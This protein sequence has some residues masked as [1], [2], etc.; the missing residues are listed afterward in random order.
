[1][2]FKDDIILENEKVLLRPLMENDIEHLKHF[3][4]QEPEI[5]TYSLMQI[6][7]VDDLQKYIS[8]AITA[9]EQET[10][11]PFI[12]Y[13]K[14]KKSYAG[15]TRFYDIQLAYKTL[16][17]GYT[18]YGSEFQGT[19]VNKNCKYLLLQHAF[20]NLDMVRVEFRADNKNE[21]SKAAMKSIGCVEE[22]V[23]RSNVPNA[24]GGR[25]DSIVLSI[26]QDEWHHQ[27]KEQLLQKINVTS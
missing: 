21:R 8:L 26:L 18:W 11:Y 19:A 12:V 22:G 25:R 27:V 15:S 3:V 13:D 10:A 24:E 6:E 5:W 7:S 2:N 20:E 4:I 9:R 16:Q 23:L 17:L 14:I 1:M